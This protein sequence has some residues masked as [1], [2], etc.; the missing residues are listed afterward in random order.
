MTPQ[1]V[2]GQSRRASRKSSHEK[3]RGS[4]IYRV[5]RMVDVRATE[6]PAPR[7]RRYHDYDPTQQQPWAF[8]VFNEKLAKVMLR[9]KPEAMPMI[10]DKLG[11]DVESS[12]VRDVSVRVYARVAPWPAFY[13]WIFMMSDL[14]KLESPVRLVREYRE[15]LGKAASAI[16]E[17]AA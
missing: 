5:D 9:A 15:R 17:E 12:V 2:N 13:G 3:W 8:G 11:A 1:S 16:N 10:I 6:E 7:N 4:V 14:V